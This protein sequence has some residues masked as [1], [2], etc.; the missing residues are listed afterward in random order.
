MRHNCYMEHPI[1]FSGEMVRAVLKGQ[2][3]QTRRVI[4]PQPPQ[5]SLWDEPSHL[6]II[7]GSGFGIMRHCPYGKSG[8]S[9]WVR[10]T[11]RTAEAPGGVFY[12]ADAT[13]YM[14][15]I[16]TLSNGKPW[17]PS[18]HMPRWASRITLEMIGLRVER[19]QDIGEEDV[20]AEGVSPTPPIG[21]M[22]SK[23]YNLE[24][25]KTIWDIINAKRGHSWKSNPWVWVISFSKWVTGLD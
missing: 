6:F 14:I 2:K 1:I 11:W 22:G 4:N 9:L 25:F 17:R 15:E 19:L 7:E 13:D 23:A 8:D 10:E 20:L 16:S 12:R 18:I 3:T 5:D 24:S 21:S